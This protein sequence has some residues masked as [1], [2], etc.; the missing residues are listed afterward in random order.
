MH[1]DIKTEIKAPLDR[2][3]A[4]FDAALGRAKEQLIPVDRWIRVSVEKRPLLAL[5]GA[6]GVG[7]VVGRLLRL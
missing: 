2:L 5:A 4:Q 1:T 3:K 6:L 7:Y